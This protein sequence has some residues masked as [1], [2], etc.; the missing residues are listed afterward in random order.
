MSSHRNGYLNGGDGPLHRFHFEDSSRET[1]DAER[2]RSRGTPAPRGYQAGAS[3]RGQQPASR[4]DRSQ[5]RSRED[6][7]GYS[8]QSQSRSRSRVN[9]NRYGPA[10]GQV[11]DILRYIEQQWAFMANDS[12]VPVKVALQLM[13][14]SSLGLADQYQQFGEA[15]TQ[16]QNALKVIVNEH[17]QGFNSSIGT[18]HKIQAA[19]HTS[20]QRVRTLRAGLVQ[21]KGSLATGRPELKAFAQSSQSYDQMLQV[22]GTI[23][24]LQQVPEKLEAQISEK[25]FLGAVDILQDALKM[26]RKPEMEEI[27][28]LSDL[29]VYLSNQEH[30]LTDILIEELHNHLYLKSPYCEERWKA[31]TRRDTTSTALD[32]GERAMFEFLE[33]FDASKPM[34]EDTTRN[35]EA[36][37]F[38]YIQLIV[39]S[40][41]RMNRLENA[42][43]AIEHRLPVELFTVVERSHM[44]VEQ[45]HPSVT[46]NATKGQTGKAGIT[47]GADGERK[48]TLEDLLTTLFAKYEAIAEGHRVLY[49]VTA[50]IIK[51]DDHDES[52]GLNR[53]FRE[54]WKLLQSEIRSLLHDHLATNGNLEQRMRQ[55]NDPNTN[56]FKPQP[57]DK[58]RRLFKLTDT[59]SKSPE[60][61]TEREDLEAILKQSVPGLVGSNAQNAK[62]DRDTVTDIS[63]TGHKLLVEPSVFNMGI[64][65]KPSL[66]FLTRLRDVVP[67]HSGVVP[68]TLTSFLDDFLI[69]VFYPQLDETLLDL[70]S[71]S[72]TEIDAFQADPKWQTHAQRPIFRGTARFYELI[73]AFCV[74]LDS[75]P[76]DQSFSQLIITQMRSYYDKCY[77]WSKSL[78]Q[79]ALAENGNAKMRLAAHLATDGEVNKVVIELSKGDARDPIVLAEKETA[80]LLR[81][82][83]NTRLEEADLIVD[84][85]AIAA[86][87][88]LHTSMKWLAA[89]CKQLRYISPRAIDTSSMQ[90]HD[91]RRWT[92]IAHVG[93]APAGPYLPLDQQTAAGFDA[94]IA[95]FTELS[96]LIL[97]TLHVDLRLHLLHG[98]YA[99]MDTTYALGQP[100]ND[101]DPAILNLAAS[102]GTY[103]TAISTNLLA[104][105]YDFLTANL[106]VLAN[107]ALVSL[108]G[109]IPALDG[110]GLDRMGLNILVL[111][112]TLKTAMQQDA[113]LDFAAKFYGLCEPK[114]IV[115]ESKKGEYAPE[116]LKALARLV[117]VEDRDREQ[118]ALD[119]VVASIG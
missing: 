29:K 80:L 86:L 43:D 8:Q 102:L 13:D 107:N 75:L 92:Q 84:R 22:L 105:Q 27:G 6:P 25:R 28:A 114:A 109:C 79:R 91:R 64:L 63:A 76:H 48:E 83:K 85:K 54:L 77:Q 39:E 111:Q 67:P 33:N 72:M 59:D 117:W 31:H 66:D 96:S 34:L 73:Q 60:L 7:Y 24:Q 45:R 82:I 46:R 51:R 113:S 30:S 119:Q 19:I 87:C 40:L 70:C 16:L 4:F 71:R 65:L 94:V 106:H 118:G 3:A 98:I 35:P 110:H 56:I 1:S 11:E 37:T 49:D 90:A 100:Y 116:D 81:Q 10:S 38:A 115:V 104:A 112:Q 5:G 101:P 20:Q 23:E 21:A 58:T 47:W 53:S 18:F 108:V 12:C 15:H 68:S 32:D 17:H 62:Q 55:E 57:R 9:A 26:M 103:D 74:M 44:E 41:N 50:A 88:T 78:L 97:R 89:Q 95:S 36:D 61:A 42:V 52:T 14:N 2:S 69:N 99:A 93:S